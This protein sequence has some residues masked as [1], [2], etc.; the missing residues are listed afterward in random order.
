MSEFPKTLTVQPASHL[1]KAMSS[2]SD[3]TRTN[4]QLP[5]AF[6]A[7]Q[8]PLFT[9]MAQHVSMHLQPSKSAQQYTQTDPATIIFKSLPIKAYTLGTTIPSKPTVNHHMEPTKHQHLLLKAISNSGQEMSQNVLNISF[10]H[11][12]HPPY[13]KFN[14]GRMVP[15][16]R[17]M[18][19]LSYPG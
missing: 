11:F 6:Q 4:V 7:N 5:M 16:C 15:I 14:R 3:T 9:E 19:Q 2:K 17:S 1:E 18:Q 12:S 8:Q 10:L 13:S